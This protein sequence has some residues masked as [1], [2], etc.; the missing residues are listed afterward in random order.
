MKSNEKTFEAVDNVYLN[1]YL[2]K[3]NIEF[4]SLRKKCKA[5]DCDD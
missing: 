1:N 2:E 5:L 3:D 4:D